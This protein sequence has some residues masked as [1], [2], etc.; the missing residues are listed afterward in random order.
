MS[1]A[2]FFGFV[3]LAAC[4][5]NGPPARL[6][7]PLESSGGELGTWS[8]TPDRCTNAAADVF[9]FTDSA[10]PELTVRLVSWPEVAVVIANTAAAGGPIEVPFTSTD[11]CSVERAVHVVPSE[12]RVDVGVG[13]RIECET[14]GGGRV[15]GVLGAGLCR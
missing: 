7:G 11:A 6:V 4:G 10:H 1:G 9:D 15:R 12:G 13:L 14:P 8:L 5:T 3:L 2:R